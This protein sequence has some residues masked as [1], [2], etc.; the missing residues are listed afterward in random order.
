MSAQLHVLDEDRRLR[1]V[2]GD[3]IDTG[4]IVSDAY[5]QAATEETLRRLEAIRE[6]VKVLGIDATLRLSTLFSS[7]TPGEAI[8]FF[9]ESW[10]RVDFSG[11]EAELTPAPYRVVSVQETVEGGQIPFQYN[12][13]DGTLGAIGTYTGYDG[14]AWVVE[15]RFANPYVENYLSQSHGLRAEHFPTYPPPH[16][17]YVTELVEQAR[18]KG[19]RPKTILRLGQALLGVP[20]AYEG[21][22]ITDYRR[23]GGVG[24]AVIEDENG[25][26]HGSF[27]PEDASLGG[28][29]SVVEEDLSVMG[30]LPLKAPGTSVERFEPL[31]ITE[32]SVGSPGGSSRS[33]GAPVEVKDTFPADNEIEFHDPPGLSQ[34]QVA[35][36][37]VL[38]QD[39][40]RT[41]RV[42]SPGTVTSVVGEVPPMGGEDAA[43]LIPVEGR[44][45]GAKDWSIQLESPYKRGAP[46]RRIREEIKRSLPPGAPATISIQSAS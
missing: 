38:T 44:A 28:A 46:K 22:I 24:L 17:S 21:G 32:A 6:G 36:L 35:E 41:L 1:Q 23:K 16:L 40:D 42:E 43:Y 12:S 31:C 10:V 19:A 9:S 26:K 25:D 15:M 11:G 14:S 39:F 13:D 30:S 34:G 7:L 27:V 20:F 37:R 3:G 18:Q 8:P 2:R 45:T 33:A 4:S 29:Y 5:Q